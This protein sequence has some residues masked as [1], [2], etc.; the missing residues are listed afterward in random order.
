MACPHFKISVRSRSGGDSAVAGSAYMSGENLYSEY[1]Q[2]MRYYHYKAAEVM[3]KD[4]LLPPNAPDAYADRQTLWNAVEKVEKQWNSQL[5]RDIIIALPNEIPADRHE[6]LV[7]EFCQEQF[8]SKGMIADYAIHDKH[9]GNP[10]VHIMLTMRPMD[11]NGNWLPKSRKVYDLD[12]NGNRIRLPSGNWKSHKENTVDWNDQDKAELWRSS[13]ADL[14]NSK[15]EKLDSPER[16]DLRSYE[17]QGKEIVPTIHLG[18]AVAHME[19]KGIRTEI[20]DYNREIVAHNRKVMN[21][22]KLIVEIGQRIKAAIEKMKQIRAR[23]PERTEPLLSDYV[24]K[25][26]T[27]RKQGR[28]EWNRAAQEKAGVNDVKLLGSVISWMTRHKVGTLSEFHDFIGK[29]QAQFDRLKEIGKE[30]HRLETALKHLANHD[31]L[32]PVAQQSK[33]GFAAAQ[34]KFAET[35]QEELDSFRK[36]LRYMRANNLTPEDAKR[37]TEK[38][39][40]LAAERNQINAALTSEDIDPEIVRK[41]IDCVETVQQAETEKIEP[42]AKMR[43]EVKPAVK[44]AVKTVE[45]NPVAG[46]RKKG[47][48]YADLQQAR[49][50]AGARKAERSR[51]K[52][53][54]HLE[55]R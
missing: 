42:M 1:D 36:S 16:I 28:S 15:L 47:S 37:L 54:P 44:A 43:P 10:H 26:N 31:K 13:W 49:A 2:R 32:L 22:K 23:K 5:S 45:K 38:K 51:K 29:Y 27:I 6:E 21:L 55:E 35:H 48:V 17:R 8:V 4:V 46:E 3:A 9:D 24:M 40:A 33:R 14:V 52:S 50:E 11:E 25:Y 34:K 53:D 30:N 18:P 19:A 7:R 39:Q 41:I 20:G 12:E